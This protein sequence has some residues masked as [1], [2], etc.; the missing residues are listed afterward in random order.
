MSR[1]ERRRLPQTAASRLAWSRET[2]FTM[3]SP[4]YMPDPGARTIIDGGTGNVAF[5][6]EM[7]GG[8]DYDDDGTIDLFIGDIVADLGAGANSGSVHV[9]YDA[10]SLRGLVFD[11]DSPPP[12]LVTTDF[13]GPQAGG[14]TGDTALHGDFDGDGIADLGFSSPHAEALGRAEAGIL[15]VFFG[16]ATPWPATIDLALPLPV[17]VRATEVIGAHG[18]AGSDIGDVLCYSAAAADLDGDGRVDV[19]TNEMLGNGA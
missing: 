2:R 16:R 1:M 15:H 8:L 5:G 19:I 17:G 10:A 13:F 11:R 14:I 9:F 18:T 7:L 6:E 12:G 4:L 3:S